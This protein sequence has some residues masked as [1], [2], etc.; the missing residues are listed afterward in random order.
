MSADKTA[1][2][3]KAPKSKFAGTQIIGSYFY[4]HIDLY[5]ML[6][7]GLLWVVIF[8]FIPL[9]GLT[10]AF[11]NFQL[12]LGDG[13]ADAIYKSQWVG[14]AHFE[15]LFISPDFG[16]ALR[17]TVLISVYK[18]IFLFPLPVLLALLLNELRS[19]IFKKSIQTFIYLPHFLSWIVVFGVFY[20]FMGNEGMI[21][22]L[23]GALGLPPV[24]F[25][26]DNAVFRSV[27]VISDGWKEVGWGTIIYLATIASID[28]EQY[29]A[30][31]MDGAGRFI[32]MFYIT[33][34]AMIPIIS[35]M[36]ILR[37]G[38]MLEA[39][40]GQVLAMYNPAVYESADIIQTYVYRIGLGQMNFSQAT[41]LGLFE[42]VIGL[43][44][45]VS[46]NY[47]CRAL[48]GRSIW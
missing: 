34:P 44:L 4:K 17:N 12:F 39:G 40:F 1:L 43:F 27:L 45:V 9:Y 22:Q 26:T 31:E 2:A 29:E 16:R 10:I 46:G 38:N 41:A 14:L 36:L 18:I 6:I 30:A 23:L 11:K 28:T 24:M 25:F 8:K 7:P 47:L 15:S 48:V 37:L 20:V 5:V 33:L 19:A 32:K 42:S 3:V 21:N 35:L 13:I